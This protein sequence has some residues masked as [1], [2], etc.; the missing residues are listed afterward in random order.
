LNPDQVFNRYRDVPPER[1]YNQLVRCAHKNIL[2]AGEYLRIKLLAVAILEAFAEVT[3]GDA[4]LSLFMGDDVPQSSE[5]GDRLE[6]Y[7]PP[8]EPAQWVDRNSDVYKLLDIGQISATGFKMKSSPLAF[9]LHKSLEPRRINRY[10]ER[11]DLMFAGQLDARDF[12]LEVDHQIVSAIAQ[13]SAKM[14]FTRSE[15]LL[16]YVDSL[17]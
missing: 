12:L 5:E 9:F 13:A 16:R 2:V 6:N 15:S 17:R 7:L 3:G 11:A 14:A 4:P 10:L 1:E 8:I